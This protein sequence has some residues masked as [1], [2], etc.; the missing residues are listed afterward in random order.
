[1]R[2]LKGSFVLFTLFMIG[3]CHAENVQQVELKHLLNNEVSDYLALQRE[4]DS[5]VNSNALKTWQLA[6]RTIVSQ[7]DSGWSLER[8]SGKG[9]SFRNQNYSSPEMQSRR[10]SYSRYENG[11]FDLK[12]LKKDLYYLHGKPE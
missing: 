10:V 8:I 9:Q 5:A 3:V 6:D 2:F 4:I 12:Q 7:Y 11:Y 1:M